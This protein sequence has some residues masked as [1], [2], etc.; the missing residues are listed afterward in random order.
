MDYDNKVYS[1][2][3]M[4]FVKDPAGETVWGIFHAKFYPNVS[5]NHRVLYAMPVTFDGELPKMGAPEQPDVTYQM[6][7]NPMPI[8]DR[9]FGFTTVNTVTPSPDP[10]PETTANPADTDPA[11][12]IITGKDPAIG[13]KK[14][15][16]LPIAIGAAAVAA[17]AAIV[18]VEVAKKKKK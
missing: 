16:I 2:G 10:F 9:I 18:G 4:V 13:P 3:A 17:A 1:P 14:N 11:D 6:T 12:E 7:V 15:A 8:N 5:Y